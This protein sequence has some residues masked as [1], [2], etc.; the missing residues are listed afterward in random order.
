MCEIWAATKAQEKKLDVAEMRMWRWLCG[1][2]KIDRIRGERV[3]GTT[4]VGE[5]STRVQDRRLK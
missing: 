2:K 5:I 4:N 1:V 3:R